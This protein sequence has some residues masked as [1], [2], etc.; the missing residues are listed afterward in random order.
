MWKVQLFK[1]NFDGQEAAAAAQVI[2]EGWLTMGERV[3]RFEKSFG[4]L[5]S[6]GHSDRVQCLAVTN[7]TAALQIALKVLEVGPGDEVLV[8]GFTFVADANVVRMVNAVPVFV[9]C[10]SPDDLNISLADIERKMTPRTKAVI[11][12]HFAGYPCKIDEIQNICRRRGVGLIEDVAHAP[13][14]SYKGRPLGA[15]GDVGCF[16]FFSNK[17]L[18]M[19]EGGLV[20]TTRQDLFEKMRSLR[21]HGMTTLTL[22]RHHG[23]AFTYDVVEPGANYRMDEMHA[24]IGLVQ[25]AKLER[26]NLARSMLTGQYRKCLARTD[27]SVPFGDRE[28]EVSSYHVMPV[29]LP[30]DCDRE[31]VMEH[32]KQ[33]G[34][35]TSIH[36]PPFWSFAAYRD[37]SPDSMPVIRSIE[38]RELTL[39]LYPTMAT[40]E[41]DL[42]ADSLQRAVEAVRRDA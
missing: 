12:V 15:F 25:L 39:P 19:G 32:M 30:E 40:E 3:Q 22:D 23:R 27:V 1:L 35:Q 7:C 41:V 36:Y 24:A 2:E 4:D 31:A 16:S 8:P 18:S 26:A 10:E 13:G 5:L 14:A 38:A 17:N 6:R 29:L 33:A 20:S 34:I 9:D 28:G 21:S 42:V 37:V 11:V